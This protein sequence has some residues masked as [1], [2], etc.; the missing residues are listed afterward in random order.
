MSAYS[1][2]KVIPLFFL[3]LIIPLLPGWGAEVVQQISLAPTA[4]TAAQT[5]LAE[6][7][8]IAQQNRTRRI[9]F[10]PGKNSAV[11]EDA[12]VR[13]TRDIYLVGAKK[14]QKMTINI[15][16]LEDNGV[17]EIKAPNGRLLAQEATTWSG[18]LP[19]TGDYQII[20]GGTRGN[21]AYK[22]KVTI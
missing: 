12:V 11:V 3:S 13:G 19:A 10:A 15:T 5:P 7:I 9:K 2:R 4:A 8:L 17:F 21:A 6:P 18:V 22:I 16:S 1:T 14:R 20:V